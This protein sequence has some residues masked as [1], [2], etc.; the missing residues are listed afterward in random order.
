M[1]SIFYNY[2]AGLTQFINSFSKQKFINDGI[3]MFIT[4]VGI[5]LMVLA[6]AGQ[7]WSRSNRSQTRHVLLT[8]GFS[9]MFALT[10]N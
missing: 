7:W 8:A 2:D 9:F 3:V 10:L 5:P 4:S 6:V 1:W